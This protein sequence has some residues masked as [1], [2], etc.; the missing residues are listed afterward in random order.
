M[1]KNQ[2]TFWDHLDELRN[3]LTWCASLFFIGFLICYIASDHL[4]DYLRY[5][6]FSQLPADKQHL[7]YTGLFEN[8]LVHLKVAGYGSLVLFSPFYFLILWKFIAPG[9]RPPERNAAK[10]FVFASTIFF[11]VGASFAYFVLLPFGVKYFLNYGT[12]AEV[13]LLT[14]DSYVSLVLK[15]LLCFGLCFEMPVVLVL[16]AKLGVV[17]A[18]TLSQHRK[19]ALIIIALISAAIAPPDAVSM[20]L[21]MVPLYLL[22]EGAILMIRKVSAT[23]EEELEKEG[24]AH[25][26]SQVSPVNTN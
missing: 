10:P 15:L 18:Q 2:I 17:S 6:L 25:S 11:L 23:A 12:P 14:L 19:T 13:A 26:K 16:L 8:F 3:K 24:P 22:F 1:K 4:L 21:L 9:L 5:P 7:Y 20:I